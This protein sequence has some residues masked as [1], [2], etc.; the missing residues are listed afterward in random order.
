MVDYCPIFQVERH[1]IM[2]VYNH[3]HFHFDSPPSQYDLYGGVGRVCMT[4]PDMPP[5]CKSC[6]YCMMVM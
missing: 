5:T 1:N 4:A 3:F 6:D 2:M